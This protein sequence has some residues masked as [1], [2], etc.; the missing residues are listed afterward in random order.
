MLAAQH[1]LTFLHGLQSFRGLRWMNFP[2][3]DFLAENKMV[4]LRAALDIGFR[5]PAT[6]VTNSVGSALSCLH[7]NTEFAVKGLDTVLWRDENYQHFCFTQLLNAGELR[8]SDLSKLPTIVQEQIRPKTDVRV[9]VVGDRVWA[10]EI[11]SADGPIDGDWRTRS[12]Q[13]DYSEHYLPHDVRS[14]CVGIVRAL[15][16]SFAAIDLAQCGEEY[17]YLELNPVGEWAWLAESLG[18]DVA[19]AMATWLTGD[20]T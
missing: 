14:R 1:W 3:S 8:G 15:N 11:T 10:A 20:A 5:I 17:V 19:C 7:D 6:V 16:L 18:W 2:A 12:D 13:A 9:T 4:Q